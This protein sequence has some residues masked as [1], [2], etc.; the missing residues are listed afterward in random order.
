MTAATYRVK[1]R[2]SITGGGETFYAKYADSAVDRAAIRADETTRRFGG[3]TTA[4]VEVRQPEGV[5]R[6]GGS[7]GASWVALVNVDHEGNVTRA[8][9]KHHERVEAELKERIRAAEEALFD[10]HVDAGEVLN[11]AFVQAVPAV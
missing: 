5:E 8:D 9:L 4:V 3:S 2:N 1:L 6:R 11:R 7:S 10:Y